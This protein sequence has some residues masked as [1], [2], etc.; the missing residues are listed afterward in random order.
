MVIITYLSTTTLNVNGLI[1][2]TRELEW[3]NGFSTKRT[4]V[5]AAYKKLTS[6]VH[7]D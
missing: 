5:H 2:Q 4:H 6:D 7:K 1:L 3:L